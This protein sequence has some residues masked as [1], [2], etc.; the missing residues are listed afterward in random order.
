MEQVIKEVYIMIKLID[1]T[2]YNLITLVIEIYNML[3]ELVKK[4]ESY[5]MMNIGF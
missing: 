4:E 3:E 1:F 5:I 2:K